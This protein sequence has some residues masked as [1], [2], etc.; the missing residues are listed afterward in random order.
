VVKNA[1]I[2]IRIEQQEALEE[3]K[4]LAKEAKAQN[5]GGEYDDEEEEEEEP[6]EQMTMTQNDE[7]VDQSGGSNELS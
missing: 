1:I 6:E 4:R 2:R 7:S 5:K 3:Q